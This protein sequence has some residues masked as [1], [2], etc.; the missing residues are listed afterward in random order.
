MDWRLGEAAAPNVTFEGRSALSSERRRHAS[1]DAGR[2]KQIDRRW[3]PAAVRGTERP[4]TRSAVVLTYS[5]GCE[6]VLLICR[7][8]AER[9]P[10]IFSSGWCRSRARSRF[11]SRPSSAHRRCCADSRIRSGFRLSAVCWASTGTRAV[12]RRRFAER[13]RK[14]WLARAG[15][16]AETDRRTTERGHSQ[17]ARAAGHSG[18]LGIEWH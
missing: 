9:H 17:G 13:S 18:H 14:A 3:V 1:R 11:T 2:R 16:H 12:S 4:V 7:C 6:P 5:P 10:P 15:R 8:T